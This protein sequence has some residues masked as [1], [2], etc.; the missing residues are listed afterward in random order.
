MLRH[1]AL[2]I[3]L[4]II[5]I[6]V[7]REIGMLL[8]ILVYLHGLIAHFLSGIFS[9]ST[10]GRL[11]SGAISLMLTPIIITALPGFI[12]WLIT[13]RELHYIYLIAWVVWIMLITC[14]AFHK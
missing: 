7:L 11:F 4:S 12:Y 13:R 9:N 6:F 5:A 1:I 8:N 14:L 10:I 3:L 2:L